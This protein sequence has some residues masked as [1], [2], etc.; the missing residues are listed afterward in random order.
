MDKSKSKDLPT[1]V[2]QSKVESRQGA[3]F[4][5][6]SFRLTDAGV[7]TLTT[8]SDASLSKIGFAGTKKTATAA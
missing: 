4:K 3:T 7:R 5:V 2:V 8:K 6:V 1:L